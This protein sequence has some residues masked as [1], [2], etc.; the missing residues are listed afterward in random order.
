M[1]YFKMVMVAIWVILTVCTLVFIIKCE[2][3]DKK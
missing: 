3:K 1:E 2:R